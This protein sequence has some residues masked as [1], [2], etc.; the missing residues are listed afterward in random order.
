MISF[1]DLLTLVPTLMPQAV[2]DWLTPPSMP[3][4]DFRDTH[5]V[6]SANASH[7]YREGRAL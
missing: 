4:A 7:L 3:P 6:L 1:M 2:T 5:T